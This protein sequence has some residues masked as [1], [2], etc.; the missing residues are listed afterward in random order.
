MLKMVFRKISHRNV[1]VDTDKVIGAIPL[2][3][4]GVLEQINLDC[5][6]IAAPGAA[7]ATTS[8]VMYG[9]D[10]FVIPVVDPDAT[11]PYET[12]YDQLVPK[13]DRANNGSS[14]FDLDTVAVDTDPTF[15]PGKITLENIWDMNGLAP[16]RIFQR[17]R[18]L[19]FSDIGPVVGGGT[20]VDDWTP[21]ESFQTVIKQKVRVSQ[22]SY[23]IVAFSSPALDTTSTT[24]WVPPVGEAQ[25]AILQYMEKFLEDAFVASLGMV[26]AGAESPYEDSES[27][28]FR[29]LEDTIL[30][31]TAAAFLPTVWDVFTQA[32]FQLRVPGRLNMGSKVLS[33]RTQ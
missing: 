8:V 13:Q 12:A 15:E 30:E 3:Q 10:A 23:V 22:P 32:T 2:P 5:R 1:T 27:Y 29:M 31:D 18:M 26:E 6:V 11:I 17:R 28:I 24:I 4:G 7:I 14:D 9:V 33:P 25:W 19:A 16:R 20:A 21:G